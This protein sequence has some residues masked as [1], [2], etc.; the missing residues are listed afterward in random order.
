MFQSGKLKVSPG[1]KEQ[2]FV[3]VVV[4]FREKIELSIK[5]S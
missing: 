4:V 3:V 5:K 2:I 1:E